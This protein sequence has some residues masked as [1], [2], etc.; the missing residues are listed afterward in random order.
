VI[1]YT[2]KK[3][4]MVSANSSADV[5]SDSEINMSLKY[6]IVINNELFDVDK[7][8]SATQKLF[9][10]LSLY[11]AID[12]SS[13][14]VFK[15]QGTTQYTL[16]ANFPNLS[17]SLNNSISSIEGVIGKY[18]LYPFNFKG[19][20]NTTLRF[21]FD[22]TEAEFKDKH[23]PISQILDTLRGVGYTYISK[24]NVTTNKV[25]I[26]FKKITSL[27]THL[28]VNYNPVIQFNI[29]GSLQQPII[30]HIL[31]KP[32]NKSTW[33]KINN[34]LEIV[35]FEIIGSTKNS[36]YPY[37]TSK[38][39]YRDS[40]VMEIE[41]KTIDEYNEVIND[42][43]LKLKDALGADNIEIIMLKNY[44]GED[45]YSKYELLLGGKF[46]LHDN[47]RKIITTLTSLEND[48]STGN[49]KLVFGTARIKLID[50]IKKGLKK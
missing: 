25:D 29:I 33:I 44:A 39:P 30:Y 31:C 2:L 26:T 47:N 35:S 22:D 48:S 42:T 9:Y 24:M 41:T 50:Q 3:D 28:K 6:Y 7:V 43:P 5:I 15:S 37:F 23:L 10:T 12:N 16:S 40:E 38:P 32:L 34:S 21:F 46:E 27:T 45:M 49:F 18:V 20:L 14:G 8:Q 1:K 11:Y 36:A 4:L 13:L 19:L 17:T